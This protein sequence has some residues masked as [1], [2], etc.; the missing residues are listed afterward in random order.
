MFT[1]ALDDY[2]SLPEHKQSKKLSK[3]K[4]RLT[5]QEEALNKHE[6]KILEYK[7][8]G[9]WIYENF[10]EIQKKIDTIKEKGELPVGKGFFDEK[11][12][13]LRLETGKNA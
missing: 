4:H 11:K 13:V 8:K 9:D 2:N 3:L 12:R 1:Q 5:E 7:K 6:E 10:Q